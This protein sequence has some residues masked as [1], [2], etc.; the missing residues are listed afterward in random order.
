MNHKKPNKKSS[1]SNSKALTVYKE[2][3]LNM[4]QFFVLRKAFEAVTD[5]LEF[6]RDKME[7]GNE[8]SVMLKKMYLRS[9]DLI[10][11][12]QELAMKNAEPD[13]AINLRLILGFCSETL[14]NA[15][16]SSGPEAI[17]QVLSSL[18][19]LRNAFS[20]DNNSGEVTLH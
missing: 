7:A 5:N 14:K 3:S 2:E 16:E 13:L 4:N 18:A 6:L 8:N 19:A 15:S 17:T 1:V 11:Q 9:L 12:F 20:E 10:E